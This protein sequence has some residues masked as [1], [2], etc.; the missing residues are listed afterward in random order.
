MD[1][2][3]LYKYYD[4]SIDIIEK[5]N[6]NN[7]VCVNNNIVLDDSGY[8]NVCDKCGYCISTT[9]ETIMSYESMKSLVYVPKRCYTKLSYL[10]IKLNSL[11]RNKKPVIDNRYVFKMRKKIKKITINAVVK[12]MKKNKLTM[13][14]P[15]KTFYV[16]KRKDF[17]NL[18]NCQ[19]ERLLHD[20]K[21]KEN[22]YSNNNI[23]RFNYNFVLLKIFEEW[24][25]K[26]LVECIKILQDEAILKKHQEIY[27]RIFN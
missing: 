21:K 12:Y 24:N 22:V 10:R 26:E 23:K 18:T 8:Y 1:I 19:F 3:E 17:I 11:L 27:K 20:F 4:N 15:L 6:D 9:N 5:N 16:L 14:D 7:C 25:N 2:D 13:Y